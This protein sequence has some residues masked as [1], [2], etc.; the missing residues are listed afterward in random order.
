MNVER[1]EEPLETADEVKHYAY[2]RRDEGNKLCHEKL[3]ISSVFSHQDLF[4][5]CVIGVRYPHRQSKCTRR[6]HAI[7]EHEPPETTTLA[8]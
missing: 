2:R 7:P 4:I 5:E 3:V 8:P 1:E 6:S